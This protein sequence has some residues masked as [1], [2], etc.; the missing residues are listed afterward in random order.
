VVVAEMLGVVKLA[1][2]VPPA[3]GDPPVA[4][5]YQSMVSP[6]ETVAVR[7]TVPGPHLSNG[8]APTAGAAGTKLT[9]AVTGVLVADTQF[10]VVFFVSA[11]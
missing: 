3:S 7:T 10:V 8:P 5:A 9:V 1:V 6:P 11:K 2:P 4:A